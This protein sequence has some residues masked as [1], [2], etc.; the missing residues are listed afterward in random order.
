V[1]GELPR[2]V[3]EADA[4]QGQ[5]AGDHDDHSRA[6]RDVPVDDP[7]VD[8]D[9]ARPHVDQPRG[10]QTRDRD[11]VEAGERDDLLEQAALAAVALAA[12]GTRNSAPRSAVLSRRSPSS[13]SSVRRCRPG[14]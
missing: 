10:E 1:V 2:L 3:A 8:A 9:A 12:T 13:R 11:E 6:G 14:R 4:D 5:Q 7:P